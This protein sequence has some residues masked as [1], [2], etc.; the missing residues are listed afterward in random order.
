MRDPYGSG[1]Y[2]IYTV[3]DLRTRQQARLLVA[4]RARGAED[5]RDLLNALDLIDTTT[6]G[7]TRRCPRCQTPHQRWG[8]S[9]RSRFCSEGCAATPPADA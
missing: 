7:I 9:A 6:P 5:C 1:D 2:D 8:N 4:S 3:Q